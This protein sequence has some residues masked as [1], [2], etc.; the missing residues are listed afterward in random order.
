VAEGLSVAA[1]NAALGTL[2]AAYTWVQLHVGAPGPNGTANVAIETDRIQVTWSS[3]TA[4]AMTNTNSLVWLSVAGSED[5]VD[6]TLWSASIAGT[7]G[8]SG[9]V[10]ANAVI[11]GDTFTIPVGELDAAF[12][13]A[14]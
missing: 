6:A 12:A 9:T 13:T 14:S 2:A 11:A 4:G 8:A 10:T 7:F 5:Y 3:P 1:A